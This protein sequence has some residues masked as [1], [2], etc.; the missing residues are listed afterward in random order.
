MELCWQVDPETIYRDLEDWTWLP[1]LTDLRPVMVTVFADVILQGAD[2]YWFLD[3]MEGHLTR[4]WASA[5]ELNRTLNTPEGQDKYLHAGLHFMAHAKGVELEH[6][7]VYVFVPPPVFGAS[8]ETAT[9]MAMSLRV[10]LAL[11][12]QL[13]QQLRYGPPDTPITGVTTTD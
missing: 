11:S 4:E 3:T 13:H 6:R 12:G 1:G 5:D 2:G 10:A 9:I 7:E 8:F